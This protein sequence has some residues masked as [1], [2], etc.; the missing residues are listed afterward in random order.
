MAHR[1]E[2]DQGQAERVVVPVVRLGEPLGR[3]YQPFD[4]EPVRGFEVVPVHRV[5]VIEARPVGLV[6][7]SSISGSPMAR[8]LR[9][10]H[11]YRPGIGSA[12]R[13]GRSVTGCGTGSVIG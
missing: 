9:A 2:V 4:R 12:G 1:R 13:G 11:S 7:Q 10:G 6:D 5:E 3:R 8:S